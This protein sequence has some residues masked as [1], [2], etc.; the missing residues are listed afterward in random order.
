MPGALEPVADRLL[1]GYRKCFIIV[2]ICKIG[3][4]SVVPCRAKVMPLPRTSILFR[5][6]KPLNQRLFMVEA[7]GTAPGPLRL[8]HKTFIAIA[9]HPAQSI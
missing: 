3:P 4:I 5:P 2:S 6:H 1:S 9:G 8:F 7:P